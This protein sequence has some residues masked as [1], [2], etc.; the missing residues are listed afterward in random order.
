V[1]ALGPQSHN[2]YHRT[3]HDGGADELRHL[4]PVPTFRVPQKATPPVRRLDER[5][6]EVECSEPLGNEFTE[7]GLSAGFHTSLK[8][9]NRMSESLA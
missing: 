3:H 6:E 1:R 8:H 2:G 7:V 5:C 4:A 9:E